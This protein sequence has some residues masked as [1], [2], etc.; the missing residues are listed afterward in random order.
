[1]PNTDY[2]RVEKAILYL[3]ENFRKQ[4][5]LEEIAAGIG[6]SKYHFQ[7]LFRRWAGIS[8]KRFLQYLTGQYVGHLLRDSHSV[9]D[10]SLEA[11]LSGPGRLHDLV[12]N[13]HGVTPGELKSDGEGIVIRHGIHPSPFGDC[14]IAVTD[15]G[16]CG[17]AFQTGPDWGQTLAEHKTRWPKARFLRDRAATGTIAE[18]IFSDRDNAAR[19]PVDLFVKGTNFQ[20]KVWEALLKIPPGTLVSYADI[21][22]LI[23]Q[24]KAA[25]A[26]GSANAKNQVALLIPCHRVI[27]ESG[28]F[29]EYRWGTTRK[30]AMFAWE[31][32]RY[33]RRMV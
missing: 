10:A 23:D 29:G 12:V 24:P 25:R 4:P 9:L 28:I 14:L 30:L 3:Q 7:R 15:R 5:Q 19:G 17:L 8:P 2:E 33:A 1:M 18:R 22:R 20:F 16:V 13:L 32:A 31:R 26:V 11:G 27:R 6:V 21:A